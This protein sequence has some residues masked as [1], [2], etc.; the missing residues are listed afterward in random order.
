N[1]NGGPNQTACII[2]VSGQFPEG[3][4]YELSV[5]RGSWDRLTVNSSGVITNVITNYAPAYGPANGTIF[6]KRCDM[7]NNGSWADDNLS[8]YC[9]LDTGEWENTGLTCTPVTD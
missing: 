2:T 6:R 4:M 7:N 5:A 3:I 1:M 8:G 9:N